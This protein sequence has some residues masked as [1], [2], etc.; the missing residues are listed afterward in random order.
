MFENPRPRNIRKALK[1][2]VTIRQSTSDEDFDFLVNTH[3]QNIQSIGG[4]SK[5]KLFFYQIKKIIPKEN[6]SIFYSRNKRKEGCCIIT[7]LF[8]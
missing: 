6:Y 5:S 8:Q 4:E 7:F 3:Q 2:G 1:S